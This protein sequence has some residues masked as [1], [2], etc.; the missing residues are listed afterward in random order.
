MDRE[1][2]VSYLE[3]YWSENKAKGLLAQALFRREVMRGSF[4]RYRRKFFDGCWVLAPKRGDFFRFRFCFFTHPALFHGS[5]GDRMEPEDIMGEAEG[6]K[7]RNYEGIPV[8]K[9]LKRHSI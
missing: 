5:P 8:R 2:L 4:S 9:R 6:L 1:M 7:F 3:R